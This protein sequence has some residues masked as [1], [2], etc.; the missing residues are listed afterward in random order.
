MQ[1]KLLLLPHTQWLVLQ[2]QRSHFGSRLSLA[3]RELIRL[4]GVSEKAGGG[5]AWFEVRTALL[6]VLTVHSIDPGIH[7]LWV[8]REQPVLQVQTREHCQ[9]HSF[10]G[11]PVVSSASTQR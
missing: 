5:F 4:S 6:L 3:Q 11:Y 8:Q 10:E 2:E 1:D 7:I 9:Q